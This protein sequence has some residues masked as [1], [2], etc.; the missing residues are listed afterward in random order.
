M[1]NPGSSYP[2]SFLWLVLS[3]IFTGTHYHF[4]VIPKMLV[5]RSSHPKLDLNSGTPISPP[6][7]YTVYPSNGTPSIHPA[8]AV[9]IISVRAARIPQNDAS[10]KNGPRI[11]VPGRLKV[12]FPHVSPN[13]F[14]FQGAFQ[15]S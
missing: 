8:E 1:G 2:G 7:K 5:A 11:D 13:L 4:V 14:E 9:F 3:E 12:G 10:E 6:M 15:V